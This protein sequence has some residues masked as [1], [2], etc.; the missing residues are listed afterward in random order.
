[1]AQKVIGPSFVNEIAAA[2]LTGL[3]IGFGSNGD[4]ETHI[5]SGDVYYLVKITCEVGGSAVE[6]RIAETVGTY[7]CITEAQLTTVKACLTAHDPE[8]AL[9]QLIVIRA[10]RAA[11]YP[12]IGDQLD[13]LWKGG[14]EQAKMKELIL[15]VKAAYPKL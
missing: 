15:A 2:G 4:I 12:P 11:A 5:L 6:T 3:P 14:V 10:R 8:S 13:A 1:M 7:P 9:N